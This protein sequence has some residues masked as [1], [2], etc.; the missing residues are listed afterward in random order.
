MPYFDEL[1]SVSK[2]VL[3]CDQRKQFI[4]FSGIRQIIWLDLL[5]FAITSHLVG[6]HKQS[7]QLVVKCH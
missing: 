1:V 4:K 2:N 6:G 7:F 5:Q 3:L